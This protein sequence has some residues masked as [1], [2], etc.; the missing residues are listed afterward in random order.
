[1]PTLK[2]KAE[3]PTAATIFCAA[4]AEETSSATIRR[5]RGSSTAALD[6]VSRLASSCFESSC[7][8][9]RTVGISLSV[10][11]C[12][13]I[14]LRELCRRSIERYRLIVRLRL[15]RIE[16]IQAHALQSAA[17]ELQYFRRPVGEVNDAPR[18]DRPPVINPD[19]H[20]PPVAQIRDSHIAA[21]R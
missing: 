2:V 21:Q 15:L 3:S 17:A 14:F 11:G 6:V 10:I 16:N 7:F 5:C 9:S 12:R 20:Y 18:H 19:D 4:A 8:E 1:M 13:G